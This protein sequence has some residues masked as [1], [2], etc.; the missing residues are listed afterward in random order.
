M[1]AAI[2]EEEKNEVISHCAC[3]GCR[4]Y[5]QSE[6]DRSDKT[7]DF[8]V[9]KRC[10]NAIEKKKQWDSVRAKKFILLAL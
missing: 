3:C 4:I 8:A 7:F 10:F 6:M 5:D 2:V 1:T 9:C